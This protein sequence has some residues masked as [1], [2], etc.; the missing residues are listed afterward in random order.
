MRI[1]SVLIV[2]LALVACG[3]SA[4]AQQISITIESGRVSV[5]ARDATVGEILNQWARI[6]GVTII[7]SEQ[8][9]S[10]PVTLSLSEVS[11]REALDTLLR[12][13]SGYLLAPRSRAIQGS[14]AYDRIFIL[15][16]STAPPPSAPQAP[17]QPFVNPRLRGVR[18]VPRPPEPAIEPPAPDLEVEA[19]VDANEDAPPP[20][21]RPL[22]QGSTLSSPAPSASGSVQTSTP[23]SSA[24]PR[25]APA[26]TRTPTFPVP[27]GSGKPGVVVPLPPSNPYGPNTSQ[28]PSDP[29]LPESAPPTP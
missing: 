1:G 13:V 28:F 23:L 27:V 19:N 7:G 8:L 29:E 14:S 5:N 25:A 6:A 21:T 11:E 16:T 26:G 15:P 2:G 17:V 10:T 4:A 9:S 20:I 24:S 22:P 18:A 12:N 3:E